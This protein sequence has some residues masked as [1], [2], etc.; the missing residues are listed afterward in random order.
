MFRR[1]RRT[2][3]NAQAGEVIGNIPPKIIRVVR[4]VSGPPFSVDK[5]GEVQLSA[6]KIALI[7]YSGRFLAKAIESLRTSAYWP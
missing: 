4:S 7:G 3:V 5:I 6:D 1:C 2:S